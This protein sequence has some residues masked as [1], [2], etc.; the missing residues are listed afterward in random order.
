MN[1]R[2]G[3]ETSLAKPGGRRMP[4]RKHGNKTSRQQPTRNLLHHRQIINEL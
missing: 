2:D 4:V 1:K 3:K